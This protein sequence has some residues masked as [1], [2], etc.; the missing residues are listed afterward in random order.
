MECTTKIS[1]G[2]TVAIRAPEQ[3]TLDKTAPF[4]ASVKWCRKNGDSG[5]AVGLA[6]PEDVV[7]DPHW[8]ESL[9][10]QIG[11]SEEDQRREFIRAKSE[12]SGT[13]LL[14]DESDTVAVEVK[15][16]GM[17]GALLKTNRSMTQ[18]SPFQLSL[19]PIDDLPV[20]KI[21]GTILRVVDKEDHILC[22]SSFQVALDEDSKLLQEYILK[23]SDR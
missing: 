1:K 7:S 14:E 6:L 22:P 5:Y 18:N 4:M 3:E 21:R 23:F 10:N 11:Y 12:I 15:N 9:L 2:M 19:G 8:L 17:G 16:L 20:L 13:L